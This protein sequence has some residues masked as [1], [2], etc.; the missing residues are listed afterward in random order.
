MLRQ[1]LNAT[2]AL[3]RELKLWTVLGSV[4]PLTS[5]HRPHN[6]LYVISDQG[7]VMTRYD[8]RLL[9]NTKLQFMYTPGATA[10]TFEINGV[11]QAH[12]GRP[13]RVRKAIRRRRGAVLR[14]QRRVPR[15][16]E[17]DQHELAGVQAGRVQVQ[18]P[19]SALR[20]RLIA[21]AR[22]RKGEAR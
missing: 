16:P 5:A 21:R 9:S 7:D 20:R 22:L 6:S 12:A 4:H 10:I 17:H 8:E 18:V 3:A 19:G 11:R 2:A 15:D 1:E 13:P 14:I